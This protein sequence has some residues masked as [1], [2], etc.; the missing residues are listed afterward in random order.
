MVDNKILQLL[1]DKLTKL[2]KDL[3]SFRKETK[4]GFEKVHDRLDTQ[5]RQVAYL[6]DDAPT[7]EEFDELDGR[8]RKV[9]KKIVLV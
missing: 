6:E 4:E 5:G 8:V 7:R 2:E 1:L 9:E 3:A